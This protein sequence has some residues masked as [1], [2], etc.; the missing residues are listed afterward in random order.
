[1]NIVT[2]IEDLK[3]KEIVKSCYVDSYN[4]IALLFSDDT[5]A[6]LVADD[7]F[8]DGFV[9]LED[10]MESCLKRDAGIISESEFEVIQKK[11]EAE[12][13]AHIEKMEL[14][15]LEILREKYERT[16]K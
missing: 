8:G 9:K 15:Q 1:M 3:G 5:F 10:S 14:R 16:R 6:Y 12:K 11:E 13:A 7:D 2:D 4:A